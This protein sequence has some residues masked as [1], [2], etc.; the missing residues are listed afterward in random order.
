MFKINP[1]NLPPPPVAVPPSVAP[2]P[3]AAPVAPPA[4]YMPPVAAPTYAPPA[5][6]APPPAALAPAPASP[7][8]AMQMAA[9]PGMPLGLPSLPPA[10]VMEA[11]PWVGFFSRRSERSPQMAAQIPGVQEGDMIHANGDQYRRLPAATE[12]MFLDAT[13]SWCLFDQ[14]GKVVKRWGA[15]TPEV[16]ALKNAPQKPKEEVG[17]I[18][19]LFEPDGR[20]S[21][22]TV[23]FRG[24]R[25][26]A[27]RE[28][29]TAAEKAMTAEWL[30]Q[31]PV[32]QAVL[33]GF[34]IVS[35]LSN[36]MQPSRGGLVYGVSSANPK[37]VT[38]VLIMRLSAWWDQEKSKEE[39]A[40]VQ[41]V[42]TGR[43]NEVQ[44]FPAA[45]PAA[46]APVAAA[47]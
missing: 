37:P 11:A 32:A 43:K 36:R 21:S 20:V 14:N 30:A 15:Y 38:D 33:P 28:H 46:G 12:F 22:A 17:V 27:I 1:A 29:L 39:F 4:V 41:R 7:P 19:I 44:G 3:V 35:T 16:A 9:N 34:R 18:A 10:P 25:C 24:A 31:H 13:C 42:F 45:A 2:A 8:L 6:V 5:P 23:S 47:R 40:S 26:R